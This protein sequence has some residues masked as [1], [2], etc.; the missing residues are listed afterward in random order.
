M[1]VCAASGG[2]AAWKVVTDV[3]SAL[4]YIH[5]EGYIFRDVSPRNVLLKEHDGNGMPIIVS[6]ALD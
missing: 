2:L 4:N 5:N 3:L 6:R 1:F